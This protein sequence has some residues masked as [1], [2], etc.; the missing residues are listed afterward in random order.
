MLLL[1]VFHTL[2]TGLTNHKQYQTRDEAQ[3]AYF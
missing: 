1:K 2:K 3:E